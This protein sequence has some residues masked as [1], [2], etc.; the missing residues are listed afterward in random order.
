MRRQ[1]E[2]KAQL[3]RCAA[4]D[5]GG[6]PLRLAIFQVSSASSP[7]LYPEFAADC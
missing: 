6:M 7:V 4:T 1:D 5:P 3:D 2:A